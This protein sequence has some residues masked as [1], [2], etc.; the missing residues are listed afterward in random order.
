MK[1][2]AVLGIPI[3]LI[4]VA[5]TTA[6]AWGR[7]GHKIVGRI[8][9]SY[10]TKDA[11]SEIK[12]LL[13]N[14]NLADVA[15][16]ADD[17]REDRPKTKPYHFVN[18]PREAFEVSKDRDY[19]DDDSVVSAI[20]MYRSVL[21]DP[22]ASKKKRKEAL[23]FLVHFVGDI[24]QPLH[25][26]YGDDRGG[27]DLKVR[28]FDEQ[29]RSKLHAVWD[30]KL[31]AR[32]LRELDTDCAGMAE[33]IHDGVTKREQHDWQFSTSPLEWANESY[34]IVK[35]QVYSFEKENKV[36]AKYYRRN[37]STV[38]ERL[39]QAGVRLATLLNHI[40]AEVED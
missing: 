24:H 10:L 31:I 17:V 40:F 38:E 7:K 28:F 22:D 5:T 39:A 27:N 36:E 14:D 4:L 21:R 32:R 34:R 12:A 18:L 3:A 19:P 25:A 16:W 13:D 29:N 1:T 33:K 30:T 9:E 11:K 37:F 15:N 6:S 35:D 8:A 26:G 23:K 2:V 20:Y